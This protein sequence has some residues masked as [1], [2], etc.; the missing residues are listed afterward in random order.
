[1]AFV[2]LVTASQ[3]LPRR[4]ALSGA[5][6]RIRYA[7]RQALL[8]LLLVPMALAAVIAALR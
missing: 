5:G 4:R 3:L 2:A 6:H 8:A 7:L 1:V